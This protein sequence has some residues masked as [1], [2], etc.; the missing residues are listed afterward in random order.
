MPGVHHLRFDISILDL[1][2]FGPVARHFRFD[3]AIFELAIFG[4][5]ASILVLTL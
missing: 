5:V 3:L 4:P 2:I 1:S